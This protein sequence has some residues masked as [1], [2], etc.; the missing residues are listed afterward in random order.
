MHR[1]VTWLERRYATP[2][3]VGITHAVVLAA[4]GFAANRKLMCEHAL[5]ARGGLPLAT[6]GDDGSGIRLGT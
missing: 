3:R 4:G 6:P 1:P 2:L 5:H